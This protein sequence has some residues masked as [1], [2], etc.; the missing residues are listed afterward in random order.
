MPTV[1]FKVA[2]ED[3]TLASSKESAIANSN[4]TQIPPASPMS[5]DARPV[6]WTHARKMHANATARPRTRS[7][8]RTMISFTVLEIYSMIAHA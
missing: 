8:A 2:L 5:A 4:P 3:A 1:T 6:K 7:S